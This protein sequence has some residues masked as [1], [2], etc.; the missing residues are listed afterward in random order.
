MQLPRVKAKGIL[1]AFIKSGV[2]EADV[3]SAESW[4]SDVGSQGLAV[5]V[6]IVL[7]QRYV[8]FFGSSRHPT[9]CMM[10]RSQN[11][12]AQCRHICQF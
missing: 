1:A 3:R 7:A 8:T 2:V 10:G 9:G 5:F 4:V 6:S 11:N 12:K